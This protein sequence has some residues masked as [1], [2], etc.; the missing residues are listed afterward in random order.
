[1]TTAVSSGVPMEPGAQHS[2]RRAR[3]VAPTLSLGPANP[4]SVAYRLPPA[5]HR[6]TADVLR[7]IV[8]RRLPTARR[9]SV[10]TS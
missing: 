2:H 6:L 1:V 7:G 8:L 4:V 3:R 10:S 5:D 9:V